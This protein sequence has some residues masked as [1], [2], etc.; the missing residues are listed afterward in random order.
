M[1]FVAEPT[2]AR[3]FDL[4]N[5]TL[6]GEIGAVIGL[7]NLIKRVV[8]TDFHALDVHHLFVA[9]AVVVVAVVHNVDVKV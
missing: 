8:N 2:T 7:A 4:H 5:I 9:A 3:R 1:V 6:G